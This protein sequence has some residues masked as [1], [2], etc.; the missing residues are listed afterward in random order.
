MLQGTEIQANTLD[1]SYPA[2][3]DKDL[4]TKLEIWKI[5]KPA[6]LEIVAL[7]LNHRITRECPIDQTFWNLHR[8]NKK[9]H[10]KKENSP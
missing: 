5:S 4:A 3:E 8:N 7:H 1:L 6:R 2:W 9:S 10:T